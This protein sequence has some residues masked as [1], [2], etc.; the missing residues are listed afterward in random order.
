M[1]YSL[2]K[3]V[4]NEQNLDSHTR[5]MSP[6][7]NSENPQK[8]RKPQLNDL[9]RPWTQNKGISAALSTSNF[10]AN[11]NVIELFSAKIAFSA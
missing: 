9:A 11:Y 6:E 2:I 4:R 7:N 5:K 10:S 1:L 8:I 3:K